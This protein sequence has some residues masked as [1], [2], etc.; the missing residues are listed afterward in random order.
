MSLQVTITDNDT[1]IWTGPYDDFLRDNADGISAEEQA[2][3][4][5]HGEIDVGGGAAPLLKVVLVETDAATE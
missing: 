5:D 4:F 3:L 1:V 2:T